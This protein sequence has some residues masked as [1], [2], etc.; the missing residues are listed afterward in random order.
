MG[1]RHRGSNRTSRGHE[2]DTFI[3]TDTTCNEVKK[4]NKII[5]KKYIL[6]ETTAKTKKKRKR[7]TIYL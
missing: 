4:S 1:S 7:V 5:R 2:L 6:R 3:G